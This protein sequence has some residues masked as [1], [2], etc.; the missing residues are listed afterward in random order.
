[1]LLD[2]F[3]RFFIQPIINLAHWIYNKLPFKKPKSKLERSWPY[4]DEITDGGNG[5]KIVYLF[6]EKHLESRLSRKFRGGVKDD[7]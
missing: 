5:G 4:Q 3:S 2:F 6:N 7:K 1:M